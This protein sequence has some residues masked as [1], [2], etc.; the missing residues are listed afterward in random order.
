MTQ[1]VYY[2]GTLYADRMCFHNGST[3]ESIK[4]HHVMTTD[5]K[6]I[7]WAFAGNW[8]EC[9]IGDMVIR[10][11]ID[12]DVVKEA[13]ELGKDIDPN[14][15]Q[16]IVVIYQRNKYNL[17]ERKAYLS[18]YFGDLTELVNN[19]DVVAVGALGKEIMNAHKAFVHASMRASEYNWY[20]LVSGAAYDNVD[21]IKAL[22]RYVTAGTDY[23]QNHRAIDIFRP[24]DVIKIYGE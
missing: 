10:S 5:G 21:G 11:G 14:I 16:G 24:A 13:R 19:D 6:V 8:N 22:I 20:E 1:I 3:V 12:K 18:N 23:D 17:W 2:K 9:N 7:A 15:H 4:L